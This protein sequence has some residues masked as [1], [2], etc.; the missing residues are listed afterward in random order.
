M[1][2]LDAALRFPSVM[3]LLLIAGL[4]LR[5][6]RNLSVVAD[7]N[8]L[9]YLALMCI[10]IAA[11]LLGLPHP[12]LQLPPALHA[13]VRV[14]DPPS[15]VLIWWFGRSLFEDDF[16]LGP[17]EWGVMAV[18]ALPVWSFRFAELGLI[19]DLPYA[20]QVFVSAASVVMMLHLIY[21]AISG[22]QDDVIESRRRVRFYFT[23]GLIAATI[24]MVLGERILLSNYDIELIV[25][26]VVITFPLALWGALWLLQLHP[27]KVLFRQVAQTQPTDPEIDPRDKLLHSSLVA[28]M[29]DNQAYAEQGLTI[30]SLAEKLDTPEH[31]LRALINQGLGY[32]NFSS[33]L[34]FY[35]IE[36]VKEAMRDPENARIPVLT[37]AMN[38]GFNSLAPFN[39]AFLNL[40][41]Q[42]PTAFRKEITSES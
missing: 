30:R 6:R 22:R 41:G 9:L 7:K 31:R 8:T 35:R 2:L 42:T 5:E 19:N 17:L 15:V 23:L 37:L 32:R 12:E 34:N 27:E 36:A 39:R 25:L 16:H 29:Q 1:V 3:L 20:M 40:T 11:L 18:V 14:L 38:V 24:L 28:E 4:A 10:S 26:R 33:F 13:I 21:V